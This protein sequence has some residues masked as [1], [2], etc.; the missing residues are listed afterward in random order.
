MAGS[1]IAI[2]HAG[3]QDA[4]DILHQLYERT[5]DLSEPLADAGEALMLIHRDRFDSQTD[6][7]GVPWAPLS[8]KYQA[9]KQ[10]YPDQILRYTGNL[11]DLLTYQVT[12]QTLYFGTPME[13]GAA[14]QFGYEKRNLP[15]RPYLGL[16]TADEQQILE[17]FSDYLAE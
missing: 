8:A 5:G 9:R 15:A 12:P 10:R 7:D 2:T 1:F 11:R 17:I 6:P 13:Y 3:T 16:S 14:H 4:I